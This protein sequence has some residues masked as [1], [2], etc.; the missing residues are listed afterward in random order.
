MKLEEIGERGL[1]KRITRKPGRKDVVVGIG[2]D[3]AV[4]RFGE[5][6]LLYTTDMLVEGDHF[7][8]EWATPEQIG[9]KAMVSNISDIAAMGGTPDYALVSISLNDEVEVEFVDG[10]YRGMHEIG[11]EHGVEIIGGDTTHGGLIV[12]NIIVIGETDEEML[13]LRSGAQKG[14]YILV[15]GPLGG[16]R[17]GLELLYRG[18]SEPRG[19]I[20]KHLDPRCR[21]DIS[22]R[23]A[24]Y[25]NAMIDVSDGLASEIAHICE[26]SRVGA[27]IE[28]NNIPMEQAT[29]ETGDILGLDP[30]RFALDGGEDFELVFT[31]PS[32]NLEYVRGHGIVVGRIVEEDKGIKMINGETIDL[33]GGYDHFIRGGE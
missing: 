11:D 27:I 31:V 20:E 3:A 9:R 5:R 28:R 23:I 12:I 17:A 18:Y 16:S 6:F 15:S 24:P 10:L 22:G 21:I 14:D 19:P 8:I 30:F 29:R 2:D 13:C 1:I 26:E 7:K 32:E 4:I 33:V 25:T